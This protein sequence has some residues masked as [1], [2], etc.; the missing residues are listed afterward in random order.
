MVFYQ[1]FLDEIFEVLGDVVDLFV[2]GDFLVVQ[3]VDK[4]SDRSLFKGA[5]SVQHF[6]KYNS[7]RPNICLNCVDLAFE[8][9][10]SH[11][12]G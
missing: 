7:K 12:D 3:E 10:R 8:N 5:E 11:I 4:P 9:F 2:E 6:I 1:H